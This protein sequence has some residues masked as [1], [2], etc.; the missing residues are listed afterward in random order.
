MSWKLK[1]NYD[2]LADKKSI[3]ELNLNFKDDNKLEKGQILQ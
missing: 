3:K 1:L 2:L